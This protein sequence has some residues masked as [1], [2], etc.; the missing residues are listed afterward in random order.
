MSV[1]D[2]ISALLAPRNVVL[3]GASDRNWSARVYENL[4]R[5]EFEGAVYLVNPNRAELWGHRCYP[6]IADI[7]ETP[8]HLAI[9]V[10]AD[11][12]L[13]TLSNA[14]GAR[15]A[16]LY[17]AGFGEGDD[18]TGLA[19]AVRLRDLLEQTRI[20]AVGPNCMG[21]A[22]GGSRFCTVPDEQ[23]SLLA[24]GPVAAIT[25]SGMLV[26]TLSRGLESAGLTLSHLISCG[27]QI[28]LTF[29]DY[30]DAL[31]EDDHLRV[32]ACYVESVHNAE[33]FFAASSRA[34]AKGKSVVVVKIGGSAAAREAALAHTGSL[35]GSHAAFDALAQEAGV[36]RVDALEDLVEA[37][38]FLA[39]AR[40]PKG[41]RIALVTNSGALKSLMTEASE[42]CGVTLP[43]LSNET[44]QKLSNA[45]P[46]AEPTM[47]YDTKRT[48]ATPVYMACIQALHDDPNVDALL[49]AEELPRAQGIE[50]KIANFRALDAW[51]GNSAQ[52]PV[53]FVSPLTLRETDYMLHTRAELT[54]TPWL[55]DLTKSMRVMSRLADL[56]FPPLRHGASDHA[57]EHSELLKTFSAADNRALNEVD[58]KALL[59][60]YGI[61]SAPEKIVATATEAAEAASHIGYPV[62][63][64]AVCAS[65]PHKSDAGLVF[66]NLHDESAVRT[67][68]QTIT[69]RCAN[70]DANLEGFLVAKQI[71]GGV[72]MVIG[73]HRDPEVGP[74]VMVGAG[75]VLLELVQDVA[76]GPPGLDYARALDMISRLRCAKL[77]AGYRGAPPC[78]VSALAQALVNLGSLARDLGG[79]IDSVDVNPIAVLPTGAFALDGLVVLRESAQNLTK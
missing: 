15:S 45:L 58:S 50:R 54:N 18:P 35:A 75:G 53:T 62:V 3:V 79:E 33:R 19:R 2:N 51:V 57:R 70:L 64:K 32:I 31:A 30:I 10:P 41:R 20:A 38:S 17:A 60:A 6:S 78:D 69:Q 74:V 46:E 21:L 23:L 8:D 44:A 34:R 5:F 77:L 25:Q 73:I 42:N 37:A 29:A 40:R 39:R 16:S 49:I 56:E 13:D 67:A 22:V 26:Q 36:V 28:G 27:N 72:E 43:Q 59:A 14:G 63:L 76:F 71:I 61:N 47:P 66:L 12:T 65:V 55:R 1:V 24:P 9:F 4:R 48:L 68:V 7:P 11:Q 52:K